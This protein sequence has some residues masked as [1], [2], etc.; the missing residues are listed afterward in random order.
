[1]DFVY[2]SRVQAMMSLLLRPRSHFALLHGVGN[3][4]AVKERD[5]IVSLAVMQEEIPAR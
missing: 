1:M 4:V 2:C 3:S 5:S